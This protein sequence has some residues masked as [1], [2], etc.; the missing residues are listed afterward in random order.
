MRPIPVSPGITVRIASWAEAIAG[1]ACDPVSPV[2]V[3]VFVMAD[4]VIAIHGNATD[5]DKVAIQVR[6]ILIS[7]F[8]IPGRIAGKPFMFAAKHE[9]IP[10]AGVPGVIGFAYLL[11]DFTRWMIGAGVLLA[12]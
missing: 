2:R 8:R 1:T 4:D 11:G 7:R 12:V 10:T 6:R 5:A 9:L 3:I